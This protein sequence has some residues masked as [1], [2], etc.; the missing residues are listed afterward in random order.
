MN[1]AELDVVVI[2]AGIAGLTAGI[3]LKRSSLSA[4]VLDKG[5]PGGKINNIHEIDNYPGAAK[6]SGPDLAMNL[7]NQASELGVNYAYGAAMSVN[8]VENG[9]LVKTD[10]GDYLCKAVIVAT[11]VENKKA[12]VPGENEFLGKGV[13]Y[14]ATCDGN[15]FKGQDV[16]VY[17]YKDHAVEDAIYLSGLASKVYVVAPEPFEA[18]EAH[19]DTLSSK[20]NVEIISGSKL[21]SIYGSSSVEGIELEG[22]KK[23]PVSAIF[24]LAGEKSS[25]E[26]LSSLRLEAKNGFL[27]V[28][29]G[30]MTSCPGVFAA[31]DILMKK[32]RQLVNAAGEAAVAA[33]SAIAYIHQQKRN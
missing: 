3:Y 21:V 13:S 28:D 10:A 16:A 33:T 18:T 27:I 22:E 25:T 4:V 24:P 15:F 20:A 5:A 32:L 30:M 29:E 7:F 2:G 12:G 11:G 26:F 1:E 9:F 31:G 23:I 8:K 19:L 14:C 17:G 6:I